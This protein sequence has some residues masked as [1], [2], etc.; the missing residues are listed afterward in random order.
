MEELVKS[1]AIYKEIQQ[2]RFM[3]TMKKLK[4]CDIPDLIKTVKSKKLPKEALKAIAP[5]FKFEGEKLVLVDTSANL[6]EEATNVFDEYKEVNDAISDKLKETTALMQAKIEASGLYQ[7]PPEPKELVSTFKH[8]FDEGKLEAAKAAI[9]I[10]Y[11][12][13]T[14]DT[15][16]IKTYAHIVDATLEVVKSEYKR[17]TVEAREKQRKLFGENKEYIES[18][19]EYLT[20]TEVLI[21]EGQKA[22]VK[23]LGL[24]QQKFEESEN[25]LMEKGLAQNLLVIQSALRTK[26]K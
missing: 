23:T 1:I 3:G 6:K 10:E 9:Q 22:V 25:G 11:L 18:L 8:S 5:R 17:L 7:Q 13:G 19:L 26:V 4:G 20:N 21:I 24:S 15:L 14:V 16:H 2:R 12:P